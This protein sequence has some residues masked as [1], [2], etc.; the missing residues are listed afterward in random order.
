ML[1]TAETGRVKKSSDS[2]DKTL[3]TVQTIGATSFFFEI[4]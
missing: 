4:A 2:N 1:P 3:N